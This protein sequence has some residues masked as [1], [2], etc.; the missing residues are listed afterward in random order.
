MSDA[1]ASQLPFRVE[2]QETSGKLVMW[3]TFG[4]GSKQT[5][6]RKVFTSLE[7]LTIAVADHR[8]EAFLRNSL[9]HTLAQAAV[10]HFGADSA[11]LKAAVTVLSDPTNTVPLGSLL[12][13]TPPA[14]PDVKRPAAPGC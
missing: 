2:Y 11:R 5:T 14:P 6:R 13:G 9:A 7:A 3:M 10:A 1:P 12:H 4:S 8:Y